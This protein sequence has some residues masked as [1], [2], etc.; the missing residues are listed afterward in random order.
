MSGFFAFFRLLLSMTGKSLAGPE[1][2]AL[3]DAVGPSS[4]DEGGSSIDPWGA[5]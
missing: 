1:G 4:F 2:D 3:G 5:S